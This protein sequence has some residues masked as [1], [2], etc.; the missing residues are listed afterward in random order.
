MIQLKRWV[1]ISSQKSARWQAGK[2][3]NALLVDRLVDRS[4][5]IFMTVEP[6]LD[7]PV[8]R[9][10][11]Q[12]ADALCRSTARSTGASSRKQSSL[13]VDR[14][15]RPATSLHCHARL[16]TSVNWTGPPNSTLLDR[17][18]DRQKARSNNNRD[19]KLIFL[20]SIKSHKIT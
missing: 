2:G 1:F 14:V 20:S 19:K 8:D 18:V 5:V 11:I 17:P 16:C 9:T 12:R 15:G 6:P 7:H 3:R 10:W 4:T 13:A